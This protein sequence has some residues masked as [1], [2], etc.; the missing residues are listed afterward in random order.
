MMLEAM[1]VATKADAALVVRQ[2]QSSEYSAWDEFVHRHPL[3]S[4]YHLTSW[5]IWIERAFSHIR[6]SFLVGTTPHSNEILAGLPIYHV[7]SRLLGDRLV[8]VPFA[9]YC[10]PLLRHAE[11]FKA[12]LPEIRRWMVRDRVVRFELK[13]WRHPPI[14]SNS[15][16]GVIKR[17]LHHF[18][19]LGPDPESFLQ[20]CSPTSVRHMI[21]KARKQGVRITADGGTGH[22]DAFYQIHVETRVRLGLPAMPMS[23]FASLVDPSPPNPAAIRLALLGGQPVA[24]ILTLRFRDMLAV[25]YAGDLAAHRKSGASQLLYWQTIMAAFREG[26]TWISLGRT[27][28]DNP[29]LRAYKC[30][31]QARE[32]QLLTHVLSI[33]KEQ[34]TGTWPVATARHLAKR[35]IRVTP[36][37]LAVWLGNAC[38]RHLG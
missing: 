1:T 24:A 20:S 34:G 11:D 28:L 30:H 8:T 38:Y 4:P 14:D 36:K 9:A 18:I 33:S 23:L 32:E 16:F 27:S 25:E 3:G 10:D 26:R 5:K 13:T 12:F 21:G 35:I 29:G 22:L 31:W 19:P 2:L 15:G 37:R 6:G 17:H 7:R